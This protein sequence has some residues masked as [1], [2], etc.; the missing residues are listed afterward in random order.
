MRKLGMVVLVLCLLGAVPVA[1]AETQGGGGWWDGVV[2]WVETILDE[3][4]PDLGPDQEA[5]SSET[6]DNDTGPGLEPNG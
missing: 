2:A 4:L 5:S 6:H 1:A 3:L